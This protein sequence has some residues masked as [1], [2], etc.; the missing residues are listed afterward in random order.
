MSQSRKCSGKRALEIVPELPISKKWKHYKNKSVACMSHNSISPLLWWLTG[1]IVQVSAFSF[2][3]L[4]LFNVAAPGLAEHGY[5]PS[6]SMAGPGILVISF[7]TGPKRKKRRAGLNENHLNSIHL[8]DNTGISSMRDGCLLKS[9]S[10]KCMRIISQT[11]LMPKGSI[12]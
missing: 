9:V 11:S 4:F 8:H 5:F 3:C 7:S 1:G 6:V 10:F 12:F 2:I